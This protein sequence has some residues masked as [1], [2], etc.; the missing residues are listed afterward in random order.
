MNVL[1]L[2]KFLGFIMA[3]KNKKKSVAQAEEIKLKSKGVNGLL[4]VVAIAL[5]A[6]AAIGS[7]Y[8]STHF[9]LLVRVLIVV[10]LCLGGLIFAA[11]TN[12]GRKAIGFLKESR[13]ELRKIIWP[14]RQETTQT[15]F[16]VIA[17]AVLVSL[18]I[19]ALDSVIVEL[20]TFLTELRF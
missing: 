16:I 17:I 4:W 14:T 6:A 13:L 20:V 7:A 12:Q 11:L 15:T 10:G 8:F 2:N 9:T 3:N 5:L 18:V 1:F 19:W